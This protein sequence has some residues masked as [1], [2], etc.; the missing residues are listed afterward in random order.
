MKIS[1]KIE[2]ISV[3]KFFEISEKLS[4]VFPPKVENIFHKSIFLTRHRRDLGLS[5]PKTCLFAYFE[6]NFPPKRPECAR[7][8]KKL[9]GLFSHKKKL[10]GLFFGK[11][12]KMF[13]FEIF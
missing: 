8:K 9:D 2:K 3:L 6:Y 10:D 11:N 4:K 7:S 12:R 5:C 13:G 1:K